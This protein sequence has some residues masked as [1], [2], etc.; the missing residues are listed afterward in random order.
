MYFAV[1]IRLFFRLTGWDFGGKVDYLML[2]T[3]E[4]LMLRY[5]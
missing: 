3:S 4:A 2:G 5:P 1:D